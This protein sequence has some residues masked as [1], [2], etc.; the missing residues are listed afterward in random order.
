MK[1]YVNYSIVHPGVRRLGGQRPVVELKHEEKK[2]T[3][4]PFWEH[5]LQPQIR[6]I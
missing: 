3:I 4:F 6:K 1:K 2:T 5:L